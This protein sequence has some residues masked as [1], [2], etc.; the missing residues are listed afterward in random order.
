MTN[1]R[2]RT[3]LGDI[4]PAR[5]GQVDYHE[6]L[7]QI[8]PLLPGDELDD[9]HRSSQ[10]ALSLFDAG[11]GTMVE[12][13]PTDLGRNVEVVARIS[14]ATGMHIVH[15]TGAHHSGHYGVDGPLLNA[16]TSELAHLFTSDVLNGFHNQH[17]KTAATSEGA[18]IRAGMVKAGIRYWSIN[19]FE[20]RILDAAAQTNLASGVAIMVHLD[21]GSAAHEVLDIL[22]EHGVSADHV[23]LAHMDRNLD[24][25]LHTS[26]T[27]RGAYLGYDGMARH[28]EAPDSAILACLEA[29]LGHE[30]AHSRIVL[31]GDVARASRYRA[32]G[33]LPG[34]DFLPMR[35][36]PRI[37]QALG[38]EIT[39]HITT[40][41][42]AKL[43]A[44]NS[45]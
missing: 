42:P 6:H 12:A 22:A 9:E 21:Y 40:D 39:K 34:L 29:T 45:P 11:I 1:P 8:S 3:M 10:E 30:S 25:G 37:A 13:T 32:Y 44:F 26:L 24:P 16:S 27:D 5:L 19:P 20:R 35:F 28:R 4:D 38:A 23:V 18:P 7:F 17:G 2:V 43:L 15:V 14:L 31:G 36:I 33:G 41:N